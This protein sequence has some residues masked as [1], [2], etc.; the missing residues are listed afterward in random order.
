ML[1]SINSF[2][3]YTATDLSKSFC[4]AVKRFW[5]LNAQQAKVESLPFEDNSFD[6]LIALDVFEHIQ[7]SERIQSMLE[8]DRVLKD[9]AKVFINNPIT[10]N[11]ENCDVKS[12]GSKHEDFDFG[13]DLHDLVQ[14]ADGLQMRVELMQE[15]K[16]QKF[17]EYTYQWIILTR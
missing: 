10:Y 16:I 7:P 11:Y 17:S 15:Y 1:R 8:I 4:K 14:L 12:G 6:A 9:T 3:K 5:G 2:S 13:F